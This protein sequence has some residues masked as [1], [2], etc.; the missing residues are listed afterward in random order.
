MNVIIVGGGKVGYAL[1]NL[2][3]NEVEDVTVVDK[4]ASALE[5]ISDNLDVMCLK[6]S[7][8]SLSVLK[9]ARVS[10]A[11][12]F[13]AVTESDEINMLCCLAAK[14]LGSKQTIA[15][16]RNPEYSEELI[17]LKDALDIDLAINPEKET[18]AEIAKLIKFS[19]VCSVDS[20]AKDKVDLVSFIVSECDEIAGKAI[21]DVDLHNYSILFCA[22]EREDNVYIPSGDF[23]LEIK[24][25][26]YVIG[27]HKE[28]TRYFKK[29]GKY[30]KKVNNAL[31][32]GGGKICYYLSKMID[33][34]GIETKI[35]EKDYEK[36]KELNEIL[37]NSIIIH[38]DGTDHELLHS[39]NLTESDA[40]IALTGSDEE[41]IISS[42]VALNNNVS[43]VVTKVTR[44]N[45]N[46]V[47][48]N[49]GI[50]TVISPKS[51]TANKI[52]KYIRLLSDR[53]GCCIENICKIIDD[54]TEAIEI[55]AKE[56]TA[57]L[58]T[59]IMDLNINKNVLIATIV[60]D[61]KI[62]IPTGKD[63]IQH[64]DNVIIITKQKNIMNL[65]N[66]LQ[67]GK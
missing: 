63:C 38:G 55:I 47:A 13:I 64:N 27:E 1:A 59:P 15:R 23:R 33:K 17:M 49:V 42:L 3:S 12:V 6:G 37:P 52:V 43:N 8:T 46:E 35:I 7:G 50:S 39:E 51:I 36:C 21:C 66:I 4:D 28:I 53:R 48:K 30:K 44:M 18:A 62:I 24:D 5:R 31:I 10:K 22:V 14:K 54:D 60:R 67:G 2:L 16:V 41:N 65:N 56:G 58:N 45:Y 25:K 61:N 32:I 19:S 11:D 34:F 57:C 26:V 40:F 29:L 9:E 20:F